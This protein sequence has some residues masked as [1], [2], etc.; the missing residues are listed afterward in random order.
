MSIIDRTISVEDLGGLKRNYLSRGTTN[1]ITD[2]DA[3]EYNKVTTTLAAAAR[4]SALANLTLDISNEEVLSAN[5]L[6]GSYDLYT[7]DSA[8]G[9]RPVVTKLGTGE[10]MI[11]F[12]VSITDLL[13]EES[14]IKIRGA[15]LSSREVCFLY[16]DLVSDNEMTIHCKDISNS[17][18]DPSIITIEVF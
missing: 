15:T 18:F 1:P 10:Y 6:W 14:L 4:C 12:P 7:F 9:D 2:L 5:T 17:D 3:S 16:Y 11:E 8:F 13:A